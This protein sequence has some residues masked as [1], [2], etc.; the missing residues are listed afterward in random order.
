MLFWPPWP[1]WP[2]PWLPFEAELILGWFE[3]VPGG[4]GG[5]GESQDKGKEAQEGL[6]SARG[7]STGLRM[8]F[9]A[10]F[11][12]SW[13]SPGPPSGG[14]WGLL[15]SLASQTVWEAR[16]SQEPG[17]PG[18]A[19]NHLKMSFALGAS[20]ALRGPKGRR[21]WVS[22]LG[23]APGVPLKGIQEPG[24]GSPLVLSGSS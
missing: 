11:P 24:Q 13:L 21:P 5:P 18:T 9:W 7:G 19:S 17:P 2:W 15:A 4:P 6:R 3:A 8:S 1:S 22:I 20:R 14:S 16:K 12:L 23:R 10:S